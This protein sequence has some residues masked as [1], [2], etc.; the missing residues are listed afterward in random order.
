MS[1]VAIHLSGPPPIDRDV[2]RAAFRAVQCAG[3]R[4][5]TLAQDADGEDRALGDLIDRLDDDFDQLFSIV[6]DDLYE[7][8]VERDSPLNGAAV[9]A[10]EH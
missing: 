5:V 8:I 6:G 9:A 4:V 2:I 10:G 1:R 7:Y 3:G